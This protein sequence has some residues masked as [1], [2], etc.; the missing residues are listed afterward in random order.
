SMPATRSHC[1]APV[2]INHDGLGNLYIADFY[3]HRIRKID[4]GGTIT[5]YGGNGTGGYNGDGV[6]ATSAEIFN[7]AGMDLD[8]SGNLFFADDAN[9]RIRKIDNT[10]QH[11]ITTV[12]GNGSKGV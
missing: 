6:P 9:H 11:F 5:T 1:G 8:A 10:T 7:P 3:N 2:A 12:A 4:N